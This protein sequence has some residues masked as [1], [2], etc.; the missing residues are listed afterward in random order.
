MSR[1]T[2]KLLVLDFIFVKKPP[3]PG[4]IKRHLTKEA[5]DHRPLNQIIFKQI[6]SANTDNFV[7]LEVL[8]KG[9]KTKT[10]ILWGDNDRVLHMSEAKIL[11]A[12][13]PNAKSV[14]MKNVG[15]VP[16]VEKPE[17]SANIFLNFL[18]KKES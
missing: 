6:T 5:I 4:A 7:P 14:I 11:K 10:L 9:A 17:E 18:G 1:T 8:L 12:V 3:I 15:H 13:M 2:K 16:M